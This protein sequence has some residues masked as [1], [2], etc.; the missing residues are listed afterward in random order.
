MN[1]VNTL[2]NFIVSAFRPL[3]SSDQAAPE[4]PDRIS[5][6][7][8]LHV[9]S[10]YG[11]DHELRSSAPTEAIITDLMNS[12]AWDSDFY[13]VV[14]VLPKGDSM[15]VGGSLDPDTGLSSLYRKE[16]QGILRL[17]KR[18]PTTVREMTN[19]LLSFHRGDNRWEQMFDYRQV[20]D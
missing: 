17:T 2:L 10:D 4:P 1:P 18:P 19:I 11:S 20:H 12:L 16:A 3:G 15:E 6:V 5:G 14:L 9:L 7:T 8:G 13:Q